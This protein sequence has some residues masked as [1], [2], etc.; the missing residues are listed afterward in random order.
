MSDQEQIIVLYRRQEIE[1]KDRI[2]DLEKRQQVLLDFVDRVISEGEYVPDGDADIYW[3]A[4]W[5][6][7]NNMAR[8]IK[9]T[10][11]PTE[12]TS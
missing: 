7:Q 5:K 1:L 10:L 8:F 9:N 2:A 3:S 11:K 6:E 4:V 12:G